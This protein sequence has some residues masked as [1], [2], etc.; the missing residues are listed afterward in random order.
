MGRLEQ[1]QFHKVFL[2]ELEGHTLVV[3]PRGDAV[4]FRDSDVAG[5]LSNLLSLIGTPEWDR[6]P[7]GYRVPR[8]IELYTQARCIGEVGH[9]DARSPEA[10]PRS[11]STTRRPAPGARWC[12]M[13]SGRRIGAIA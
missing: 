4:G 6:L 3:A 12:R 7:Q 2:T 9:R 13:S 8:A 10:V 5:E 1:T 11:R